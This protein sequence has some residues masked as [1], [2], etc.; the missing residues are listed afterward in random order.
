[1]DKAN[2]A[3]DSCVPGEN[4]TYQAIA[5]Q[6]GTNCTTLLKDTKAFR[7]LEGWRESTGAF[8]TYNKN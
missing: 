1:M 7:G 5:D 6:F 3:V 2:A 8:S 4:F